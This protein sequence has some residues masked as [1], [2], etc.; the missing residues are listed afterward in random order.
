STSLSVRRVFNLGGTILCHRALLRGEIDVYVE[1]TGTALTA[2][3]E[4]PPPGPGERED[5]LETIGTTY[6]KRFGLS[7]LPPLGFDN[8]YAVAVRR[9]DAETRGWKTIGDLVPADDLSAGF[10]AE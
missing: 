7:V 3:L 10:T 1:Y 9:D 8:T 2:I 5:V 6:R 4:M